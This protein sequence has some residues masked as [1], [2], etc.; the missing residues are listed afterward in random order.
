MNAIDLKKYMPSRKANII[1]LEAE[2]FLREYHALTGMEF[3][4]WD[5]HGRV[6]RD[7]WFADLKVAVYRE[8]AVREVYGDPGKAIPIKDRGYCNAIVIRPVAY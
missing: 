6:S 4:L 7:E 8:Q 5:G 1:D 3:P 2:S